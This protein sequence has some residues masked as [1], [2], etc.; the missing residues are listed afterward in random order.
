MML[1]WAGRGPRRET[2]ALWETAVEAGR[3]GSALWTWRCPAKVQTVD[4]AAVVA[5]R[6]LWQL[7]RLVYALSQDTP[8]V[9][10]GMPEGLLARIKVLY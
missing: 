2:G 5:S 4:P 8:C 7:S 3:R 9:H 1:Q 6:H 10:P